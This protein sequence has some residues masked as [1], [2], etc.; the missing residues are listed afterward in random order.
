MDKSLRR[1]EMCVIGQPRCDYSFSSAR[2]CFIAYGFDESKLEMTILKNLLEAK[3]IH[4]EEAGG[5]RTPGQNAFCAKICSKIITSQFCIVLLNNDKK[6][7]QEIPNANVNMEYG[8][9]LGFNKYV[10]PFQ[11]SGQK[12]PFNVAGLDTVKYTNSDFDEESNKEI[13]QAIKATSQDSVPVD[14]ADQT[15]EM[16]LLGRDLL[17]SPTD[18]Q[19]EKNLFVLGSPLGFNLLVDF[20]G[21]SYTYFGRFATLRPELVIWRLRKMNDMLN[22]RVSSLSSKVALG[23]T[24]NKDAELLES[25]FANLRLLIVVTSKTEKSQIKEE[26]SITPLNYDTEI[27]SLDDVSFELHEADS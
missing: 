13:D 5:K 2:S 15:V 12:L 11:R 22:S 8:L 3:S 27:I 7:D 10:I 16:F 24:T 14:T 20:P 19:G 23:V 26:L 25:L 18:S 9:M 21:L 4:P 6:D 1:N 17:F